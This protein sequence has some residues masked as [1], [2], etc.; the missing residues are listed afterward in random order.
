MTAQGQYAEL[1]IGFR[2]LPGGNASALDF[3]FTQPGS[4][5][6]ARLLGSQQVTAAFPLDDLRGLYGDPQGYGRCLSQALFADPRALVAFVKG[7][8]AAQARGLP[9]RLR[10]L[11]PPADAALNGLI[12]ETLLDPEDETPIALKENLLFSR[13]LVSQDARPVALAPRGEL[14]AAAMAANP[15]DLAA[16]GLAP[17]DAAGEM[18]RARRAL[19]DIPLAMLSGP[20]AP[21]ATLDA[22]LDALRGGPVDI[23]YLACHGGMA[24]G[25][26]WLVLEDT[27]GS[28]DRVPAETFIQALRGLATPPRLVVL[29]ACQGAKFRVDPAAK[30][31]AES[32]F[33]ARLAG[34]G[35]PAV[36]AMQGDF[37]MDT[38][39]IFLPAF[40]RELARDGQIDRAAAAARLAVRERYDFWMPAVFTCLKSGKIWKDAEEPLAAAKFQVNVRDAKGT[41]IGDHNTVTQNFD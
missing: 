20:G 15:S 2:P 4:D 7:Q 32:A 25:E 10:L 1:E 26:Y 11:F 16:L 24:Q 6:E 40:F 38:A 36:L 21:P 39:E 33:A 3:S 37:S 30:S 5:A 27:K 13:V 23:L 17:V 34:A 31:V 19:Q 8:A 35:I 12:W 29:S 22:L 41:V 28:A 18:E 9:L 14:H